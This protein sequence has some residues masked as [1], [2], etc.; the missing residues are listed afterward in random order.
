MSAEIICP[1]CG[2][3][4]FDLYGLKF[5]FEHGHC[6]QYNEIGEKDRLPLPTTKPEMTADRS[7]NE[8]NRQ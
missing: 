3:D 6:D 8:G 1:F 5:H 4:D 7:Y 2:E